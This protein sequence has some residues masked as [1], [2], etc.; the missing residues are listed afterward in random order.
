MANPRGPEG[1][2]NDLAALGVGLR[3]PCHR[4]PLHQP[5]A[6]ATLAIWVIAEQAWQ[7]P[8]LVAHRDVQQLPAQLQPEQH[9]R[10]GVD[11]R[12]GDQLV[13]QQLCLVDQLAFSR[14]QPPGPQGLADKPSSG[15]RRR[16][17]W[18]QLQ[19]IA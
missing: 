19:L 18:R 16:R 6:A 2:P 7:S 11:H 5:Q 12:V 13:G 9:V 15:G 8:V 3:S 17:G 4:D 10:P 1:A 14:G